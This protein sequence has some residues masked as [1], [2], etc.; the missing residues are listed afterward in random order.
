MTFNE[1]G[2]FEGGRVKTSRGMRGAA[3]GGAVGLLLAIA[4]YVISQLTGQLL[5][6]TV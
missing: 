6:P 4:V 5:R 1:G 2:S 3:A